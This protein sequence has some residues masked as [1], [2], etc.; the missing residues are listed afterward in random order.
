MT[1]S[2]ADVEVVDDVAAAFAELAVA[3]AP[4]TFVLSGGS[5]AAA[6]YRAVASLRG[7]WSATSFLLGDERWVPV[8]HP[9][10]NEG[11]AR[12]LWL[13]AARVAAIHS[14]RAAGGTPVDAAE[15]Y[16]EVVDGCDVLDLVHLG[17]GADGHTASLFPGS[18]ALDITTRLVVASGDA[19]HDWPRVTFTFPALARARILVLTATGAAK[20]AAF[21]RA[22]AGD[23]AVPTARLSARRV[24]WIVDHAVAGGARS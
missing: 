10:S 18:T 23:A 14:V 20:H 16:D 6:C 13:D 17:L 5:T 1:P 22:R 24:I 11:Q 2:D 19:A 4:A 21:T 15:A 9:D 8:D 7:D 12:R 3:T